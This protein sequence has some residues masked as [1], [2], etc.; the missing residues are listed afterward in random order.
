MTH[1]WGL[2]HLCDVEQPGRP[3]SEVLLFDS[4]YIKFRNRRS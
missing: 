2:V 3:D 4:I 1:C